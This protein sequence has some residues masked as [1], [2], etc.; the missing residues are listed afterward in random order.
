MKYWYYFNSLINRIVFNNI[1]G[2]LD[3]TFKTSDRNEVA[4]F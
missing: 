4:K 1:Y 2:T 3:T